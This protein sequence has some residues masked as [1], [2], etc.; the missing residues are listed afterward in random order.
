M[1]KQANS[2]HKE[3]RKLAKRAGDRPAHTDK[4]ASRLMEEKLRRLV[5]HFNGTERDDERR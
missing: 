2:K 3:Q 4:Y 5:E 1:T